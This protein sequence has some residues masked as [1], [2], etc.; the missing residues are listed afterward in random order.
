[1]EIKMGFWNP[2]NEIYHNESDKHIHAHTLRSTFRRKLLDTFFVFAG[3]VRLKKS[4]EDHIGLL[5]LTVLPLIVDALFDWVAKN[6]SS[7]KNLFIR[8]IALTLLVPAGF[9]WTITN[10]LRY[11]LSAIF[12]IIL[13]PLVY[14]VHL[15]SEKISNPL[16][17]KIDFLPVH[18]NQTGEFKFSTSMQMLGSFLAKESLNYD[19]FVV[20]H[21][22]T[23]DIRNIEKKLLSLK[24][25]PQIRYDY[26]DMQDA[27]E[28]RR[29]LVFTEDSVVYI[30]KD[31]E[32]CQR[33]K[34][35]AKH[36]VSYRSFRSDFNDGNSD[37]TL[38]TFLRPRL[39]FRKNFAGLNSTQ[40][41]PCCNGNHILV[42]IY[43]DD[44]TLTNLNYSE[45]FKAMAELNIGGISSRSN[46]IQ[47]GNFKNRF[48]KE[49]QRQLEAVE[50]SLSNSI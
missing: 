17:E 4:D 1:M 20:D 16:K 45:G 27:I 31:T 12:T 22:E 49:E 24:S 2:F 29:G 40:G 26:D 3:S 21:Q 41:C 48:F 5:D 42:T 15:V 37:E 46:L 19:N 44:S 34:V 28:N 35:D 30:D 7:N 38:L 50:N 10:I 13:S 39:N 25:S 14:A 32:L 9:I 36:M 6:Y 43:T 23:P 11:S 33:F 47:E 8:A 18:V